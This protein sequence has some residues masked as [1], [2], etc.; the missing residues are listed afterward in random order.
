MNNLSLEK[1]NPKKAEL[2]TLSKKYSGLAIKGIDDKEGYELVN[3]ARKDL[4][5]Q[6]VN[7]EKQGKEFRAEAIKFQKDVIAYEKEL[8]AIIEPLEIELQSK[9]DVIDLEKN[10]I[11]M[12]ALLPDRKARLLE[13]ESVVE[14]DIIL[15]M[16]IDEFDSFFNDKKTEYLDAKEAKLRAEQDRIEEEKRIQK[17]KDDAR[18]EEAE[19][20]KK[21]IELSKQK[22]ELDKQEALRKAEAEKQAIIDKHNREEKERLET[23]ENKKK[24]AEEKA[25]VETENK[26]KLE[27][28]V[29][30]QKWLKENGYTKETKNDFV[31]EKVGDKIRLSKIVG[32]Y[33]I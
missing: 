25:R 26:A 10:K 17:A 6:R 27:K 33:K 19:K 29:K 16:N 11:K 9:Q 18:K 3:E 1:F 12:Q 14:D 30:Y 7:I 13:I 5:K 2:E 4:K 20:A 15:S 23:E 28:E 22:A 21:E 24:E 31:V 8:V 32:Y